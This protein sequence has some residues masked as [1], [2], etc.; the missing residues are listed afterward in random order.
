MYTH[1][2]SLITKRYILYAFQLGF[3]KSHSPNLALIIL[4]DRIPK[5][6]EMEI[7]SLDSSWIFPRPLVQ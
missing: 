5:A 6:L 4:V 2:V 3:R 7:L 1:L